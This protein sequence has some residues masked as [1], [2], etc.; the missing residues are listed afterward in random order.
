MRE[1]LLTQEKKIRVSVHRVR[2]DFVWRCKV[3]QKILVKGSWAVGIIREECRFLVCSTDPAT[4][5][6]TDQDVPTLFDE[7]WRCEAERQ[8][9][10]A[11]LREG[12]LDDFTL[13]PDEN[14]RDLK[15]N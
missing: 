13:E 2:K 12:N 4:C 9:V 7:E 6:H 14:Y 15:I 3:C 5:C 10:M 8:T 1:V 11:I